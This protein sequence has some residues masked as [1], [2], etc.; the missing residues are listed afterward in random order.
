MSIVLK[1]NTTLTV[2]FVSKILARLLRRLAR[3]LL[4]QNTVIVVFRYKIIV[5][6]FVDFGFTNYII[7]TCKKIK[8]A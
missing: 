5:L 1:R 4:T 7:V 3:I 8:S 2:F 6:L